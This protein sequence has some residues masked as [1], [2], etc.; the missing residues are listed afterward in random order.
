M[1]IWPMGGTGLTTIRSDDWLS[2]RE[3]ARLLGV[4]IGTVRE[5]A[6]A[7]LL[8]GYRT[9]G[10]HR[11]FARS[12]LQ[13]F[14]ACHRE[15]PPRAHSPTQFILRRMREELSVHPHADWMQQLHQQLQGAERPGEFG[16]QLLACVVRYVEEPGERAPLLDEGRAIARSYGSALAAHGLSAGNAARAVIHFRQLI[17]QSVL[18]AHLGD[19]VGDEA[20]ARL[21][22]RVSTFLDDILLAMV[23]VY[24]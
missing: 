21:F 14:L 23:E 3:A 18:D 10:G 4:H 6:D 20:D 22:Q 12:D 13:Q 11:R 24:P 19:R 15:S 8:R 9:V 5:W 16:Q 1:A 17:L 2:V 7:G